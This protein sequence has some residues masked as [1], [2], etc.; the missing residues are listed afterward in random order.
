MPDDPRIMSRSIKCDLERDKQYWRRLLEYGITNWTQFHG[1][2]PDHEIQQPIVFQYEEMIH[3]Q[4]IQ[5][6]ALHDYG[7]YVNSR[8]AVALI[9]VLASEKTFRNPEIECCLQHEVK[10]KSVST[11]CHALDHT[12]RILDIPSLLSRAEDSR[13][14]EAPSQALQGVWSAIL[15]T[16]RDSYYRKHSVVLE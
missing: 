6:A 10:T 8:S 3:L 14:A 16:T 1:V 9:L 4:F 12:R 2:L 11:H 15:R 7:F 13:E 5:V